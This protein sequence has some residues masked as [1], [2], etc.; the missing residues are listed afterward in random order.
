ME[1]SS[2]TW[3]MNTPSPHLSL[4]QCWSLCRVTCSAL[5]LARMAGTNSRSSFSLR[6]PAWNLAHFWCSLNVHIHF[7]KRMSN[8]TVAEVQEGENQGLDVLEP[9]QWEDGG[10]KAGWWADPVAGQWLHIPL[11]FL[12]CKVRVLSP[13]R[14]DVVEMKPECEVEAQ[15]QCNVWLLAAWLSRVISL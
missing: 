14:G 10:G 5:S 8:G 11:C 9:W 7:K 2:L 15:C 13:T 12:I 4:R 1:D 3:P 6:C